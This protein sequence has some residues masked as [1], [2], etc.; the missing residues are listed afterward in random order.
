MKDSL[1]EKREREAL[2]KEGTTKAESDTSNG[3]Q[4][5]MTKWLLINIFLSR[6]RYSNK[7]NNNDL[8]HEINSVLFQEK[9]I[10]DVL[11]WQL[12]RVNLTHIIYIWKILV[13]NFVGP[14]T[15]NS[16]NMQDYIY[17]YI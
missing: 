14:Y 5:E 4:H 9:G 8:F 15:Q 16:I 2:V 13:K 1:T 17:I 10:E 3:Y 6:V 11:R 7:E 12:N